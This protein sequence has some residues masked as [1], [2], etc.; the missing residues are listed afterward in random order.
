MPKSVTKLNKNGVTFTSEVD[1]ASY[2]LNELTRAALKDVGRFI[3]YQC[4]VKVGKINSLKGVPFKA[5]KY[6]GK[7]YQYWVRSKETDLQVGIHNTKYTD[8]Y[9]W[10]GADAELGL[11][12]QPKRAIL[13]TTVEENI[14]KIR[15]IESK[16]LSAIEDE[17]KAKSLINETEAI[18]SG[19]E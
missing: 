2:T 9:T 5:R 1:K 7:A 6:F 16:Y 15:E 4:S 19:E 11:N 14:D 10:F 3:T 13:T 17:L 8:K 18:G 12:K